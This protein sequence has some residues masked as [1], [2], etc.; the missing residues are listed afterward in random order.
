MSKKNLLLKSFIN[1]NSQFKIYLKLFL[2]ILFSIFNFCLFAQSGSV[3]T[4][5]LKTKKPDISAELH[6]YYFFEEKEVHSFLDFNFRR[7][8]KINKNFYYKLTTNL[9]VSDLENSLGDN[10]FLNPTGSTLVFKAKPLV[11][12]MGFN[13][14]KYKMSVGLS[15]LDFVDQTQFWDVLNAKRFSDFSLRT[16]FLIGK[17]LWRISYIP[18]RMNMPLPGNDSFWLPRTLPSSLSEGENTIVFPEDPTY[19]WQDY[20]HF[21]DSHLNNVSLHGSYKRNS[22]LFSWQY[23]WGLDTDP[24]INLELDTN[25][26]SGSTV[27]TVYPIKLIPVHNKIQRIGFGIKY[28]TPIKWRVIFEN[29]LSIGDNTTLQS[30]SYNYFSALSLEWGLPFFGDILYGT[31]QG[32]YGKSSES[33][34]GTT[35]IE[36]PLREAFLAGIE[37]RKPSYELSA[38]YIKS[39]ILDV[40]LIQLGSRINITKEIYTKYSISILDGEVPEILSGVIQSDIAEFFIGFEKNF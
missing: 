22:L 28:T 20:R 11:F 39:F 23:Y 13:I 36:P 26:L 33:R 25:T 21:N 18:F 19:E 4:D 5:Q 2:L 6:P 14:H 10:Y 37:W 27:E 24:N 40:Y 30:E 17:T 9:Q 34:E 7:Q 35:S 38:A 12:S 3:P 16:N 1:L 29:S 8:K 15:P 32:F 31:F